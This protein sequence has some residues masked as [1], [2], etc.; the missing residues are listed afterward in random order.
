VLGCAAQSKSPGHPSHTQRVV[1]QHRHCSQPAL[2]RTRTNAQSM[3]CRRMAQE[4]RLTC[5]HGISY[6]DRQVP[7]CAT[8]RHSSE[9]LLYS[10]PA[11]HRATGAYP[12]R[13]RGDICGVIAPCPGLLV[14]T[15]SSGDN[16][17][18]CSVVASC[19][20]MIRDSM[21]HCASRRLRSLS[22][23]WYACVEDALPLEG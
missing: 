19:S 20:R 5:P 23:A 11:L 6:I 14:K 1:A 3:P 10:L 4:S 22:M 15:P 2:G 18:Y 17:K 12:R 7:S 8:V 21:A 16:N 9:P 13:R